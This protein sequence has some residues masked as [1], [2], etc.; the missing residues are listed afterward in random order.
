MA[1]YSSSNQQAGTPQVMTATY[2][3]LISLTALT[4]T[5][6]RAWLYEWEVGVDALPNAVDCAIV[7]D[8]SRQSAAGS[9]GSAATPSPLD[10]A[11]PAAGTV[12]TVNVTGEPTIGVSLMVVALNQRNSQ[13]WIAR[14]EKSALIIPATNLAGIACRAKSTTYAGT[15]V[16]T[17]FF[18]E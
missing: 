8:W 16:V 3:T 14:D 5:L 17:E 2:K 9:G 10:L 11:D 7:W 4:A 1:L 13:R 6:R 12:S 18:A 15:G